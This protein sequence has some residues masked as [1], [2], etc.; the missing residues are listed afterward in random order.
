MIIQRYLAEAVGRSRL[1]W[2]VKICI[3]SYRKID[4]LCDRGEKIKTWNAN[5]HAYGIHLWRSTESERSE[6]CASS[7]LL[8][9]DT[10]H[11]KVKVINSSE[12]VLSNR[13]SQ[14]Q[15]LGPRWSNLLGEKNVKFSTLQG[16]MWEWNPSGRNQRYDRSDLFSLS[17][18]LNSF[19][20]L[21]CVLWS[22]R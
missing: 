17:G 13:L 15:R 3:K 10:D 16:E 11:P 22:D 12:C 4:T 21:M 7:A 2:L 18:M 19:D 20:C 5:L 14:R 1:W 6:K 8:V 9:D